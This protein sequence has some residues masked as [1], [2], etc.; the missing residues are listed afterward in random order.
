MGSIAPGFGDIIPFL[1]KTETSHATTV[2]LLQLFTDWQKYEYLQFELSVVIDAGE[3]FV[4]VIYKLEG[5]G[6]V[7]FTCYEIYISFL[8]GVE[9][10]CYS[11]LCAIVK[12]LSSN[13]H[14]LLDTFI[15]YG[16]DSLLCNI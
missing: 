13:V 16:K 3:P 11:N 12:K 5:D 9:L 14:S 4:K 2:K 6:T 1:Q 15:N 8:T 10:Q 7:A